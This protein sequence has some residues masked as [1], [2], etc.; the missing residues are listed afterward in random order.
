MENDLL[1]IRAVADQLQVD[2]STVR[3]WIL[4]GALQAIIL[5]HV[6]SRK[7][8]RVRKSTLTRT[9]QEFS[10]DHISA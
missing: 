5:P 9:L 2:V 7:C 3:R 10:S 1:T 4:S 8:Y 6:G